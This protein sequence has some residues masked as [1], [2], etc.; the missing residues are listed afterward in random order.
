VA[1]LPKGVAATPILDALQD[2]AAAN[3]EKARELLGQFKEQ[4]DSL[5]PEDQ[6]EAIAKLTE[7][8][9]EVAGLPEDQRAEIADMIREKTGTM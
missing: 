6:Q 8:R 3:P 9:D 1:D 7:I 4:F 2:A 5:S